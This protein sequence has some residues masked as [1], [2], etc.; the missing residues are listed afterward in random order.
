MY[1]H[2]VSTFEKILAFGRFW[3]KE[4]RPSEKKIAE[5]YYLLYRRTRPKLNIE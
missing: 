3:I 4:R 5:I 1:V 2:K